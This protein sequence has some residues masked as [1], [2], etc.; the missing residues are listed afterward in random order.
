M[1]SYHA[2]I[3]PAAAPVQLLANGKSVRLAIG[4]R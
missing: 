3:L 4:L 2:F 1:L